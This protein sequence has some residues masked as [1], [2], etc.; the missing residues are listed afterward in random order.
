MDWQPALHEYQAS[1]GSSDLEKS[2]KSTPECPSTATATATARTTATTTTT[3][4]TAAA[5]AAAAS[6]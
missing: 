3:T 4:T 1:P 5:A 6:F 2:G